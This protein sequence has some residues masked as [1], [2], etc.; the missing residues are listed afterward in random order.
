MTIVGVWTSFI[1]LKSETIRLDAEL[2]S[3]LEL[4]REL[5][6]DDPDQYAVVERHEEWNADDVWEVYLPE[7]DRYVIKLATRGI[8]M[9]FVW[10]GSE[11][12]YYPDTEHFAE[13][14]P[15][16]HVISLEKYFDGERLS[17]SVIVDGLL[18]VEALE[19]NDWKPQAG[20]STGGYFERSRQASTD[21]PLELMRI[22]FN[23]PSAVRNTGGVQGP[24]NGALLWIER[25]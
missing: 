13:I 25:K 18:A 15:G 24:Y 4:A 2:N 6:I 11:T 9:R 23:E 22:R 8:R 16:R 5:V 21:E 19:S 1:R 3:L 17:G 7:G 14:A 20:Y 10:D 12:D